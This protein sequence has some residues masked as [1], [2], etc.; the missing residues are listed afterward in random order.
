MQSLS[1]HVNQGSLQAVEYDPNTQKKLVDIYAHHLVS[2]FQADLRGNR[3]ERIPDVYHKLD[4]LVELATLFKDPA[5][6]AENE[7]RLTFIDMPELFE[8]FGEK[9]PKRS[10]RAARGRLIPYIPS[11]QILP[12]EHRDFPLEISEV[13]LGPESDGLLE[14]GVR[15]FLDENGLKH[16]QVRRSLVPLRS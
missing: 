8:Q 7:Y 15:E 12:S 3:L 14:Q 10:F 16:V 4:K 6:R 5:F 11:T 2:A 9:S 1:L 13:V